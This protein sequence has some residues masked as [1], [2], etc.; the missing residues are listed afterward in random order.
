MS[1]ARWMAAGAVALVAAGIFGGGYVVGRGDV[2]TVTVTQERTVR[3]KDTDTHVAASAA[4][5]QTDVKPRVIT[6]WKTRIVVAPD[7]TRTEEREGERNASAESHTSTATT[8]S[9]VDVHER[10]ASV[11]E[12]ITRIVVTPPSA[13][14]VGLQAGVSLP[15]LLGG[16]PGRQLVPLLPRSFAGAVSVQRRLWG[17]T[18]AGVWASSA[19]AAGL[20]VTVGF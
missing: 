13:L 18:Y 4:A 11:H 20:G 5:T 16:D 9:T 2:R 7:G 3:T 6:R 19:G 1:R 12:V 14:L 17:S 10:E 15:G 8:A